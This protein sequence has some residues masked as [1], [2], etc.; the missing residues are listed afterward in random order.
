LT[1]TI[2]VTSYRATGPV[3]KSD[4]TLAARRATSFWN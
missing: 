1:S 4:I 3:G 2:L